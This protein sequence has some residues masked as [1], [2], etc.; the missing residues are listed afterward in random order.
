MSAKAIPPERVLDARKVRVIRAQLPLVDQ[1][2]FY[3]AG[4]TGL[5]L[6]LGHRLSVDLDWFSAAAFDEQ[7]LQSSLKG[8]SEAPVSVSVNGPRT[9]RAYYGEQPQLETS[10]IGYEQVSSKPQRFVVAGVAFPVA[11][12]EHLAAMKAAVVHDRGAKRDHIDVHAI[13]RASDWSM[14]RFIENAC[15]RLPLQPRQLALALTFFEDAEKEPMPEGCA[16][17]W[18]KVKSELQQAILSWERSLGRGRKR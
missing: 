7:T 15:K 18:S 11:D 5:A 13:C 12:L 6:H 10:F 17:P 9:V 3:L 2:G 14:S 4:G 1:G 16:V 8:L